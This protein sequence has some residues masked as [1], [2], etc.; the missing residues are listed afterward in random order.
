MAHL[1]A[2]FSSSKCEADVSLHKLSH[3]DVDIWTAQS[4]FNETQIIFLSPYS[5]VIHRYCTIEHTVY[6]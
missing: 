1:K 6:I 2:V 5:Q 4:Y 3:L